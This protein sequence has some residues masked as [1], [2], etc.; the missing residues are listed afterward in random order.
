MY[1]CTIKTHDFVLWQVDYIVQYIYCVQGK[2][3]LETAPQKQAGGGGVGG[4]QVCIL[5]A[6]LVQ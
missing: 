1:L 2:S 4:N 5:N 3:R 6:V